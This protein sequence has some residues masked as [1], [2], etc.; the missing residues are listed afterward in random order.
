LEKT[1]FHITHAKAGS[2]WIRE[3]LKHSAG[4]RF[5]YPETASNH[6]R[7]GNL[8]QGMVYPTVYLPKE[9]FY[10]RL[11]GF[12]INLWG[13]KLKALILERISLYP[14]KQFAPI[15]KFVVIRDLRDTLI[16]LYYSLKHSHEI[17]RKE[18]AESR[19]RLLCLDQEEALIMMIGSNLKRAATIQ[20]SW[21]RSNQ[22]YLLVRYEDLISDEFKYFSKIIKYCG[23]K[24]SEERL[25]EIVSGNSFKTI[26]GR[27]PGDEDIHAHQRKG[28]SGD[29]Q[30]YFNP[31]IK[32]EFKKLYGDVLI[33]TGYEKDYNW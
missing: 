22:N 3:I 14:V 20:K 25:A 33:S 5:Q 23:I 10:N 9:E 11:Q 28:I 30:N 15:R 8:C 6:V 27:Q 16:S 13:F 17:I 1:V 21:I 4:D 29:W 2:Q 31:R 12:Q 7:V 24:I 19:R 18:Q 32:K 26:T